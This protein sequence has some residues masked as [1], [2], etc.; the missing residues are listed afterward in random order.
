M[1]VIIV[2]TINFL[3]L[4]M[5][6]R[7][8]QGS[9]E[10]IVVMSNTVCYTYEQWKIYTVLLQQCLVLL[11]G[12]AYIRDTYIRKTKPHRYAWLIFLILSVVSFSSQA[13]LGAKA[14]LF[15]AGWFVINNII[16][17]CL[18][19]RKDG[20]YG[21][22][23]KLNIFC[24]FL[25]LVGIVL[26]KTT[27]SPLLALLAV[28]IADAIGALLIVV[29]SY[30]EP[31]SETIIMWILGLVASI[32]MGLSVGKIDYALLA[33]PMYLFIANISIVS[34][35]ILGKKVHKKSL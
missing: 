13:A 27:S 3:Q 8:S 21:G 22:I 14:S 32:F 29:K 15:F 5:L 24:L 2:F 34:A 16:I 4:W 18:A 10:L 28:L 1:S 30:K 25:A 7:T 11:G 6:S 33:W 31:H 20:G 17:T 23:T 12:A 26:W 19:F 9:S 35:I